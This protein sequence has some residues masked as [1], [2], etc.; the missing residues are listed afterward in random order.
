MHMPACA[1]QT[2]RKYVK[3]RQVGVDG[4]SCTQENR[5]PCHRYF[6]QPRVS[7]TKSM[8]CAHLLPGDMGRQKEAGSCCS[9]IAS[10]VA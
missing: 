1:V 2:I 8:V 4:S 9:N 10:V 5:P 7:G 3:G 6:A